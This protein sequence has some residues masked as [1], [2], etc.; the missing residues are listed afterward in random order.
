V[1]SFDESLRIAINKQTDYICPNLT[2]N[3]IIL[4]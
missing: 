2:A 3:L 4:V 1:I